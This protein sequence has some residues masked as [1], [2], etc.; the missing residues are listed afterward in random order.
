[1]KNISNWGNYPKI[2]ADV[3]GVRS[4]EDG[5]QIIKRTSPLIP[6]GLGRCYGD[7]SLAPKIVSTDGFNKILAFDPVAQLITCQAG[8][9]FADLLKF[10]IPKGFF[11]PVTP[12]TK[13]ITVGGAIAS[14]VHGKNHHVDGSF[15]RHVTNLQIMLESG[16]RVSCSPA[17]HSDL[18]WAT[19]GG[20]GL[21]GLILAATFRLK[22]IDGSK[23][24]QV[25]IKARNLEEVFELFETYKSTTYS[26]AWIDCLQKDASVGRSILMVGEHDASALN[27]VRF[28]NPIRIPFFFPS[29]IL[30]KYS[31]RLFNFFY[32]YK[33]FSKL[34]KSKVSIDQ[35]FY[36]LDF[37][38]DW[39]KMY[40]HPGFVQYQ[41]VLPPH[42]AKAGLTRILN[43]IAKSGR[44]SF[45]AVL[46]QFGGADQGMLSFPCTGYTL[47]LDFP[48]K[49]GLF[50]FLDQLDDLVLEHEGRLYLTKDARMSA[51][52]FQRSYNNIELF[53][54][55]I[56]KYNPKG[57]FRSAQSD[58]LGITQV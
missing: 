19:C 23:I 13:F 21:T 2:E 11:L 39:N 58:R 34:K 38:N 36:P 26:V 28:K 4:N 20:M 50:E 45:L 3:I 24:D 47:A 7:S 9:V 29:W 51:S 54:Q 8:V 44:A 17:E 1:L 10:L 42:R 5:V 30:N 32:Y 25:S 57:T 18:F 15:T 46:K 22:K 49:N 14:D 41:F 27:S 43:E 56:L 6:R 16:E 12:G 55:T 53:K 33:Q 52:V 48:I 31:V 35:F 40:G 37:L